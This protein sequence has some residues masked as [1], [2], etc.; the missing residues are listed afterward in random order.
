MPQVSRAAFLAKL[1]SIINS[2]NVGDVEPAEVREVFT[3]LE[4]SAVWFDEGVI[5][6]QTANLTA[7]YTTDPFNIGNGSGTVRP[8]FANGNFQ[9]LTNAGA[10]TLSPPL[11]GS[12]SMILR[13]T[14]VTGAGTVTISGF[15]S[16][17]GSPITATVGHRFEL[18]IIRWADGET[19]L[20]VAAYSSN[21]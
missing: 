7:G 14:N 1:N 4:D 20:K 9:T 21:A 18:N 11:T 16:V 3:D 8:V 2:N 13:L 17:T 19:T 5:R 15:T 10:F 12:A 6:T